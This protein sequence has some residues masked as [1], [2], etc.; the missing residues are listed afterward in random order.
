ML[1]GR[2]ALIGI[3]LAAVSAAVI[4]I[5]LMNAATAREIHLLVARQQK[6]QRQLWQQDMELARLRTPQRITDRLTST[7]TDFLPPGAK[8]ASDMPPR[9]APEAETALPAADKAADD[10][11]ADGPAPSTPT[12]VTVSGRHPGGSTQSW[13]SHPNRSSKKSTR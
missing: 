7:N 2:I 3:M 10:T 8:R 13:P 5:R 4:Q 6:L 12:N 11:T 1:F 9:A